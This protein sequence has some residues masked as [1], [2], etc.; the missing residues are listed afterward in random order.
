MAFGDSLTWGTDARN[1]RRHPFEQRWPN[2]LQRELGRN[3]H[4]VAEGLGGR[5]TIYDD[6]ESLIDRN[7]AN[8]LP[9]LLSSHFPLDFVIIFLGLNDLKRNIAGSADAAV[10]GIYRLV[11]MIRKHPYR[12]AD[13]VPDVM[14]VAPPHLRPR[15]NGAPPVGERSIAESQRL[16]PLYKRTAKAVGASFFDAASVA[17]ADPVDGVHLTAD[18]TCAIG[19]ALAE[20]IKLSFKFTDDVS[21]RRE[22]TLAPEREE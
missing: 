15:S 6:P 5:T 20:Q 19:V 21:V 8:A 2:V 10:V 3:W 14:I 7:G 18:A 16:A 13:D 11:E 9:I 17:Q 1:G 12:W 4:V 22:S